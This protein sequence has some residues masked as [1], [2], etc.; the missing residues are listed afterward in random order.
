M[1]TDMKRILKITIKILNHHHHRRLQLYLR[2]TMK[3][4]RTVVNRKINLKMR[5]KHLT[6]EYRQIRQQQHVRE[7]NHVP[8]LS[9]L[10]I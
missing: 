6:R 9:I 1:S 4:L 8:S 2:M 3:N 10:K 7:S 5:R